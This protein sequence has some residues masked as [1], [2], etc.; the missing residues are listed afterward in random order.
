M[1]LSSQYGDVPHVLSPPRAGV[2]TSQLSAEDCSRFYG[3]A[4]R[5]PPLPVNRFTAAVT[6]FANIARGE[7]TGDELFAYEL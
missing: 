7:A 3:I 5:R 2:Q 4:A 6:D 1:G